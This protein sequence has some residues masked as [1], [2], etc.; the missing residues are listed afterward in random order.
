MYV[1]C[2]CVCLETY[3]SSFFSQQAGPEPE[4]DKV[5]SGFKVYQHESPVKLMH[6]EGPY[7]Y[8]QIARYLIS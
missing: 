3:V 2:T 6:S 8:M 7:S 4:Y 5:V 1:T